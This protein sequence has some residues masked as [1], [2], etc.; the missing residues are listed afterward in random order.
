MKKIFSFFWLKTRILKTNFRRK[1]HVIFH[2]IMADQLKR[3]DFIIHLDFSTA[4]QRS[5][6]F[7]FYFISFSEFLNWD[8]FNNEANF[9]EIFE[10][11]FFLRN[12]FHFRFHV[13][14]PYCKTTYVCKTC[15]IHKILR[16]YLA[17]GN[18]FSNKKNWCFAKKYFSL[19]FETELKAEYILIFPF[20]SCFDVLFSL[21]V[22]PPNYAL[23]EL[24]KQV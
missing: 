1:R 3:I 18:D 8:N 10:S 12:N 14:L 23:T 22:F 15:E 6:R 13:C 17:Y 19:N 20:F 7:L 4:S 2:T 24:N 5:F 11:D 16:F 9:S 21:C